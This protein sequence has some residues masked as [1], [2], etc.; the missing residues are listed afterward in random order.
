MS[1]LTV[2]GKISRT[3]GFPV[4]SISDEP[5]GKVELIDIDHHYWVAMIGGE[6]RLHHRKCFLASYSSVGELLGALS[7]IFHCET[8]GYVI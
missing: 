7:C 2:A 3:L 4:H 6:F 8:N 5:I 1:P